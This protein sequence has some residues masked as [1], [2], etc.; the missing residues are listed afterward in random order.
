M[1]PIDLDKLY[2]IT[3]EPRG[4]LTQYKN[5]RKASKDEIETCLTCTLPRCVGTREKVCHLYKP[6]KRGQKK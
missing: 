3:P 4:G 1:E 2:D 6:Y 5:P